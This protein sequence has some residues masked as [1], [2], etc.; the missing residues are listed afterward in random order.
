MK[1][2][3][4]REAFL[5][6]VASSRK[7]LTVSFRST[8]FRFIN[9]GYSTT[10]KQFEGK[11]VQY[12]DGRWMLQSNTLVTYTSTRPETALAEALA[13]NRYYNLPDK[14]SAPLLFVTAEVKLRNVVDLRD[15]DVRRR[16]KLSSDTILL[17]DWRKRNGQHHEAVT[18]AWGWAFLAAGVEGILCPSAAHFGGENVIVFPGN[19]NDRSKIKV[20]NEIKWP[21]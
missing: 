12:V 20:L 14:K 8:V 4:D 3:P 7:G 19:L 13:S 17:T 16:L 1:H 11:G 21:R 2:H 15:G 6:R 9:P 18:Q 10:A 5:R